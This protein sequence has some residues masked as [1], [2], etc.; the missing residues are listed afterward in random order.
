MLDQ[1][2][3][4]CGDVTPNNGLHK[5]SS[6]QGSTP[7]VENVAEMD[8]GAL[9]DVIGIMESVDKA[10]LRGDI[11]C[12]WDY[13]RHFDREFRRYRHL[14]INILELGVAAGPSLSMWLRY[15]DS[16]TVIGIDIDPS[17]VKFAR[18]RAKVLTGSQDDET[19][20]RPIVQA[21]PP[22]IIIDDGSHIAA[23]MIKSFN[24]LFP[25]LQPGGIYVVED[26]AFHFENQGG[27]VIASN[28]A[29]QFPS[30]PAFAYFGR[31][32]AA[33]AAHVTRLEGASDSVNE[34]YRDID[35]ITIIGGAIMVKKRA[36]R[37]IVQYARLFEQQLSSRQ[38]DGR[39]PYVRAALRYAE[40]LLTYNFQIP[41]AM[42]LLTEVAQIEPE[43]VLALKLLHSAL[44]MSGR[45]REAEAIASRLNASG[46]DV[47]PPSVHCPQWG[48]YPHL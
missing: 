40:F 20:L 21:Y 18:G 22:T 39:H 5:D 4:D 3:P 25:F 1:S 45:A 11:P 36:A 44:K 43:N 16:A 14:P 35:T 13:L 26:L 7:P 33:K 37:N 48:R 28:A 6:A 17:C 34:L 23:H 19:F 32:I 27:E 8:D 38:A 41:R 9:L 12:S 47:A 2:E 24:I 42:D 10:S 29:P 15:F 46:Q 30:E 31:L